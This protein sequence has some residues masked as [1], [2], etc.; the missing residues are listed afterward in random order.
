MVGVSRGSEFSSQYFRKFSV[1]HPYELGT[2]TYFKALFAA[3]SM[4]LR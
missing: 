4:D 2:F 3:V 1:Y